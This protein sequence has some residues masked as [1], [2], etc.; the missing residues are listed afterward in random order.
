MA[1]VNKKEN[2][3]PVIDAHSF[4]ARLAPR[5]MRL[6]TNLVKGMQ[7][8]DAITQLSFTHKKGSEILIKLIKSAVAN[9]EH[10]FSLKGEDLFIKQVTCDGGQVMKRY[11]PRAR[12]S[13][14]VIRRKT[15]HVH[16]VL[17]ERPGHGA[18][19]KARLEK[20][21]SKKKVLATS[22]GLP[23]SQRATALKSEAKVHETRVKTNEVDKMNTVQQKR[24]PDS[25]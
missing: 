19:V 10:N 22:E 25:E 4:G 1:E 6:V 14:F 23:K 15:S 20:K 13:A 11:F 17:E 2:M 7:V 18:A 24:R 9:A 5:K 8:S 3:K 12:G 21:V 16:V